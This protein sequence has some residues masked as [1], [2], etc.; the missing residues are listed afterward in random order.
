MPRKRV[1]LK[2][3]AIPSIFPNCPAYLTD[4]VK[5]RRLTQDDRE[6]KRMQ[7]VYKRSRTDF[8]ETQAKFLI[9]NLS[10]II[11]KLHLIELPDGWLLHRPNSFS[12]L[13]LKINLCNEIPT[14]E[15]SIVVD[16]NLFCRALYKGTNKINLASNS[17]FD[18]RVLENMIHEVDTFET[19]ENECT[20]TSM[21]SLIRHVENAIHSLTGAID[22]L[23]LTDYKL[24]FEIEKDSMRM[25]LNFLLNQLKYLIVDKHARR[26]NI[27]TQVF[28]LKIHGI[29]PA[30]YRLIQGSNCL[31]FP[32][33]RNLLK[34]KNSI[35]LESEYTKIL[36]EVAT[37]FDD[38]ERHVI[39]QMDEVHIRSDA[40]YKGGRVIGSI[41]NPDN[42]ITT[43]F[44]M[45]VS[46]LSAKCSTIARLIPLG[47]SSAER[48]YPIVKSTIYDIEA[49]G[50]FVEA[51]CTDNYPLNVRLFKSFSINSK[52][53]PQVPHPCNP[54]RSLFLFF[55]IVH[56]IKCI[57]N[58]WL[59]LKNVDNAFIFP[60]FD[61]CQ[62]QNIIDNNK[63]YYVS[64]SRA[65]ISSTDFTCKSLYPEIC[66][67]PFQDIRNLFQSDKC[68]L[69]KRAPKLTAK[70]CWPS[71]L[72]RQNVTLALKIFHETTSAGLLAWKIEN[73]N[74]DTDQT[75][76]FLN[77][78][79]QVW[80][81][82]NVNWVGKNIRFNDKF[83][84]P[85]HNT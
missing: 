7:E 31:I 19:N 43:V 41:D 62:Q 22:T 48:L 66:Y 50:L 71:S 84:A 4:A 63:A 11:S 8:E 23:D 10:C 55:D 35:G 46:S 58:N 52:L 39:L 14:V 18:I 12:I 78:I 16:E 57:R 37:T 59:N 54:Q 51:V 65:S 40:S 68:N 27:I 21:T 15:R 69:L 81:T 74:L 72:E 30:C 36:G 24:D 42:P 3:F 6:E 38:L 29:S 85:T 61:Q 76:D 79:N 33:E 20:N 9:T 44:S 56:I 47:S 49:C 13:F 45:M 75:V 34:I 80:K 83:S 64:I 70:A 28:C 17:L 1:V 53:E 32:H 73:A 5:P 2:K 26:Y 25:R 77:L 67:A 82:F 60:K